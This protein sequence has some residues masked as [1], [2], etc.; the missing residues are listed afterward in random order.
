MRYLTLSIIL[1]ATLAACSFEIKKPQKFADVHGFE[2]TVQH[3]ASID[4]VQ[5]GDL[6]VEDGNP[7]DASGD[8]QLQD[9]T[10][11]VDAQ[12]GECSQAQE[13]KDKH[14]PPPECMEWVCTG[15]KEC[16]K[17]ISV[18]AGCDDGDDCTKGD[19]CTDNGV[20]QG[21]EIECTDDDPEDCLGVH[22]QGGECTEYELPECGGCM[23]T[24]EL[25]D[26]DLPDQEC[27]DA[28]AQTVKDCQPSPDCEDPFECPCECNEKV[29]CTLCGNGHCENDENQC[30]CKKDCMPE[31]VECTMNGGICLT[32]EG[33]ATCPPG[34]GPE[35][36]ECWNGNEICCA[37]MGG[38]DCSDF[39]GECIHN[40]KA[41]PEGTVAEE[42]IG[43]CDSDQVCCI[44][45]LNDC[46]EAGGACEPM[47]QACPAGSAWEPGYGGCGEDQQCCIPSGMPHCSDMDGDCYDSAAN[48]DGTTCPEG[49]FEE[50][51]VQG[52]NEEEVCCVKGMEPVCGTDSDCPGGQHCVEGDCIPCGPEI[53]DD[54]MDNDCDGSIDEWDCE[55]NCGGMV[56]PDGTYCAGG[57]CDFCWVE[58]CGDGFDNDCDGS[59]DEFN[60][61]VNNQEC[62]YAVP[63]DHDKHPLQEVAASPWDVW[64]VTFGGKTTFGEKTCNDGGNCYWP[65]VLK[66]NTNQKIHMG[67]SDEI[68]EVY[69]TGGVTPTNCVPMG[70]NKAYVVWGAMEKDQF[71]NFYLALEGFCN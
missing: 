1:A 56:C 65:L 22:C 24:G 16:K 31:Q 17:K 35:P 67:P 62:M 47:G 39:E 52:C 53:C 14:G 29:L 23:P 7:S 32:D 60:N 27:C 46:N 9:T 3:D 58:W 54:D 38:P 11:E 48:P 59:K 2:D 57:E 19:E 15:S 33:D 34:T 28:D 26:Q 49:M 10:P 37:A 18:G 8:V 70:L 4:A 42:W 44:P 40:W 5:P 50:W 6:H 21:T 68:S 63:D 30:N 20:C 66:N 43:G 51:N 45:Q 71:G 12:E 13:C 41:C 55:D 25:F 36:W 64:K 61:C 69:C